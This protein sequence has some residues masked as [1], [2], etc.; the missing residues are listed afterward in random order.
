MRNGR[1][2]RVLRALAKYGW[3]RPQELYAKADFPLRSSP[4]TYLKRQARWGLVR[5][6][7][8]AGIGPEYTIT[9]RGRERL[10]WLEH[11]RA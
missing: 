3:L 1:K 6:R 10:A 5:K 11:T 7:T 4:W 8:V 9:R 2:L